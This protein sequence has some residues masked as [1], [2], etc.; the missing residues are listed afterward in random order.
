MFSGIHQGAM[1]MQNSRER[2]CAFL[3][4]M[5]AWE[6]WMY[7]E[8]R[9][10]SLEDRP[11]LLRESKERLIPIFDEYLTQKAIEKNDDFLDAPRVSKPP[12]FDQSVEIDYAQKRTR[13]HVFAQPAGNLLSRRRYELVIENGKWKLNAIFSWD[14]SLNKWVKNRSI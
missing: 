3:A 10:R 7:V 8:M 2:L 5:L 6:R 13:A 9:K 14:A 11:I 1:I 12:V 4:E